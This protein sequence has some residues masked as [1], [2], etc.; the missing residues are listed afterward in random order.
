MMKADSTR[1][2]R[3][4]KPPSERARVVPPVGRIAPRA[5]NRRQGIG[6]EGAAGRKVLPRAGRP[7]EYQGNSR[8][9]GLNRTNPRMRG[10]RAPPVVRRARYG[11]SAEGILA[12]WILGAAAKERHVPNQTERGWFLHLTVYAV[13]ASIACG[14]N[15]LAKYAKE[16]EHVP[17]FPFDA[18]IE[19]AEL[20]DLF[21]SAVKRVSAV[22]ATRNIDG[23]P[24]VT[25]DDN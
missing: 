7:G 6:V 17:V 25:L 23:T 24:M 18:E 11:R 12:G 13:D 4:R 9:I 3:A 19:P 14:A 1:R 22:V 2:S 21:A 20:L 16:H 10:C 8:H 15:D 5:G